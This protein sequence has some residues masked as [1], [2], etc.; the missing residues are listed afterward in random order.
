ER[1]NQCFIE[2]RDKKVAELKAGWEKG[3]AGETSG[4]ELADYSRHASSSEKE[5]T[6]GDVVALVKAGLG[7]EVIVSKVQQAPRETLDVSTDALIQLK[8][9]GV[10]KA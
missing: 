7:D 8:N 4:G 5:L 2:A 3:A 6:N 9:D 10:S 1:W